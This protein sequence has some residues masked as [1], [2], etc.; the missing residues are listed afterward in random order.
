MA[1]KMGKAG[2]GPMPRTLSITNVADDVV[3]RLER[4]AAKH[5]RSLQ[6]ELLAILEDA[7]RS[8]EAMSAREVLAEV[9]RLR[10]PPPVPA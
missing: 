10:A 6:G 5:H 1:E 4:R 2:P 7:A 8:P 9:A 3:R